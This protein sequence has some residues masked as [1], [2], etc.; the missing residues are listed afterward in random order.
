[1]ILF[2]PNTL[3]F[4]IFNSLI[5]RRV[6]GYI[7]LHAIS[8]QNKWVLHCFIE[9]VMSDEWIFSIGKNQLFPFARF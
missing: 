1:M 2:A 3:F 7:S 4:E 5:I 8:Y 6:R 9:E